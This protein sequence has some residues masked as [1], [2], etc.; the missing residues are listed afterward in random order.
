MRRRDIEDLARRTI[1]EHHL[2]SIPADPVTLANKLGIRVSNAI[3]SD[4]DL[5][6]M[7]ARRGATTAI[8]VNANDTP[9]RKRFTIAH[10]I[11]H[12]LLHLN[13]DGEL[14][15]HIDNFRTV[16]HAPNAE[17]NEERKREFEANV[18]AAALLMDAAAV[19]MEWRN[20]QSLEDMAKTFSVSEIAMSY[21]LNELGI[22]P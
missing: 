9:L 15:D 3:F 17:W 8:L 2:N 21:R 19:I 13:T 1:E 12:L 5:S 20:L 11:G 6:G 4:P 22:K 18:F 10:E 14:V 16:E 7:I